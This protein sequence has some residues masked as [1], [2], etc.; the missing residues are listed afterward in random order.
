[1]DYA[2]LAS[3]ILLSVGAVALAAA[4]VELLRRRTADLT[5]ARRLCA[6][7]RLVAVAV[8]SVLP[9]RWAVASVTAG[10]LAFVGT[11]ATGVLVT[12]LIVRAI[13][14]EVPHPTE[15]HEGFGDAMMALV[16]FCFGAGLSFLVACI[17][18]LVTKSS[19][20]S[21]WSRAVPPPQSLQQTGAAWSG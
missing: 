10:F 14:P 3:A 6:M 17:V 19:L 11:L 1:M 2:W 8:W 13:P 15:A 12:V 9:P 4:G 16:R 7:R 21:R 20:A 5:G 18:G